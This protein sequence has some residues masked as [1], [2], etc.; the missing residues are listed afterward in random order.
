MKVTVGGAIEHVRTVIEDKRGANEE[1]QSNEESRDCPNEER[2]EKYETRVELLGDVI[3]TLEGIELSRELEEQEFE[4][5]KRALPK[6]MSGL[7][8]LLN[9]ATVLIRADEGG[10]DDALDDVMSEMCDYE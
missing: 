1:Y 3:R 8:D 10:G 6:E 5:K 9:V 7:I 4:W 2:L